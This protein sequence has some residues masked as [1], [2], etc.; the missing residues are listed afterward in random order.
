MKQ[1]TIGTEK[2]KDMVSRASK[3]ASENKLIAIT[4]MICIELKDNVLTLT[5]T[6]TANYLKVI[7]DKIEG[8]DIY[9]VVNVDLF[10]KLIAKITSA[11]ITLKLTDSSVEV[12]GDGT[13]S[14][15]L[16][17]DE[18]GPVK[19]P[20]YNFQKVGEPEVIHLTSIKNILGINKA[21][22]AKSFETPCLCG[23]YMG[24]RIVTTDGD[25]ICFN[26]TKVFKA[27]ALVSPEMMNLLSLN[28]EEKINCYRAN[29]SFLFETPNV[30]VYGVSHEGLEQFPINEIEGYLEEDFGSMC[31][32][33]KSLLQN[34]VDRLSLFI[35]PYDN[36]GAYFTFTKDGMK[37]QSKKSSSVELVAY[38]E[39]KDFS[40]F[41]CCVDIPMLREQI[42]A[43]PGETVSLW[44]GHEAA[45][46]MTSGKVTQVLSLLDDE[47]LSREVDGNDQA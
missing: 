9:A 8:D 15:P 21:A 23:Y 43:T 39:S 1:M 17:M 19:F 11:N 37:V 27:P 6:D 35:D 22:V 33:S 24:D 46:K 30:I 29:D 44:Y 34:V 40:P 42:D 47:S 41:V 4:S 36:N 16:E 38:Q 20:E 18:D 12:K 31:V 32:V 45:I 14:I 10:S 25:V 28:T 7:A 3:G 5:T 2:F 26:D 13:Y